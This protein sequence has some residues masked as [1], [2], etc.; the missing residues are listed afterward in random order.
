LLGFSC[1]GQVTWEDEGVM[2]AWQLGW[3]ASFKQRY[4]LSGF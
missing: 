2:Q 3:L 4:S 1:K